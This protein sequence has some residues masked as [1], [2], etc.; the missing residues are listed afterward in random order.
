MVYCLRMVQ[1]KVVLGLAVLLIAA[2]GTF[3]GVFYGL[4]GNHTPVV[5]ERSFAHAA[6]AADAGPCSQVGR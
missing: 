2:V 5:T 1:K 4:R 3:L 6:V